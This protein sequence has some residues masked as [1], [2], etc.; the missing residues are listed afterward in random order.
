MMVNCPKCGF[1]QPKDQYCANCGIDMVHFRPVQKPF[2]QRMLGNTVVQASVL[3][4]AI[5]SIFIFVRY[6]HKADLAARIAEI[7][8]VRPKQIRERHSATQETAKLETESQSSESPAAA[9]AQPP[10][11][12]VT[13]TAMAPPASSAVMVSPPIAQTNSAATDAKTAST[14]SVAG[15]DAAGGGA[16]T[17]AL[18]PTRMRF[19]AAEV[20]MA[21]L[22]ELL[23][24]QRR[25]LTSGPVTIAFVPDL[26][27][28]LKKAQDAKTV[29]VL[30]SSDNQAIEVNKPN[31]S[32]L[33]ARDETSGRFLGFALRA[34]PLSFDE[35]G[36]HLQMSLVRSLFLTTNTPPFEEILLPLPDPMTVP[37]GTGMLIAG[38]LQRGS[39][40]PADEARYRNSKVLRVLTHDLFK[41]N[42]NEFVIFVELKAN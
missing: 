13:R 41:T 24:D 25:T 20:P 22:N 26:E 29:L 11:T 30:E 8:S 3:F 23:S 42:Q 5:F 10:A 1:S 35:S 27:T 12:D 32:Y 4:V 16:T 34:T 21:L 33:G 7:E 37:K 36:T 19:V 39:L 31:G 15:E 38:T 9:D 17:P 2:V 14:A 18:N 40:A 28:K 6:Q